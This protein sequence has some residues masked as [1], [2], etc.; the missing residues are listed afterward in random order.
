MYCLECYIYV[1]AFVTSVFT[2]QLVKHKSAS[3]GCCLYHSQGNYK[4]PYFDVCP[5][6]QMFYLICLGGVTT[7]IF[8]GSDQEYVSSGDTITVR[9]R[10]SNGWVMLYEEVSSGVTGKTLNGTP[11]TQQLY[12]IYL[13]VRTQCT[14]YLFAIVQLTRLF[15]LLKYIVIT[16]KV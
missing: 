4:S 5:V 6:F 16:F 8:S 2:H 3:L 10:S 12:A 7:R 1:N 15:S 14:L 11:K 9:G 13:T